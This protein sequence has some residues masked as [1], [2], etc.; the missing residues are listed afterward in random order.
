M[1]IGVVITDILAFKSL[2]VRTYTGVENHENV[3]NIL[4]HCRF[5][6]FERHAIE[7]IER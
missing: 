6:E 2:N 1:I 4:D 3:K 7:G 5:L